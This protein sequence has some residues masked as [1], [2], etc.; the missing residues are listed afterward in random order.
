[1]Q[2]ESSILKSA[3]GSYFAIRTANQF[4]WTGLL[5]ENLPENAKVELVSQ[6]S[7]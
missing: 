6:Y 3:S 7:I 1:M 4:I 5:H 2:T